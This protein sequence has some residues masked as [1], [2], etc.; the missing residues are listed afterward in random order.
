MDARLREDGF[1]ITRPP[2]NMMSAMYDSIVRCGYAPVATIDSAT[3]AADS[4]CRSVF[5]VQQ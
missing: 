3:A 4:S 5:P 2:L 1:R